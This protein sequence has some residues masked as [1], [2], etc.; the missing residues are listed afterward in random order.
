MVSKVAHKWKDLGIQLLDDNQQNHL[1]IIEQNYPAD[2][3]EC[4]K[5]MLSKWRELKRDASWS[6]LIEAFKCIDLD[7]VAADIEQKCK[8]G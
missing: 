5:Q 1:K 8:N 6:L 4:C 3:E 7:A 2:V